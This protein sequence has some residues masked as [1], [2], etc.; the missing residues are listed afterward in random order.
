MKVGV[1]P[2]TDGVVRTVKLRTAN[3]YLERPMT[4]DQA[5]R[6]CSGRRD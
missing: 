4:D 3:G 6:N 1:Y 5:D 2:G